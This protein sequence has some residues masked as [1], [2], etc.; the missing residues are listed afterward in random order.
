MSCRYVCMYVG[1]CVCMYHSFLF[2]AVKYKSF[3]NTANVESITV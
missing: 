3:F 1:M 2:S